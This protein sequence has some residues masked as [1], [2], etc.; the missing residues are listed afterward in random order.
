MARREYYLGDEA[1]SK[2]GMLRLEHPIAKGVVQDWEG[3]EL[4]W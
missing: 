4:I 1:Q 2:R 3:M